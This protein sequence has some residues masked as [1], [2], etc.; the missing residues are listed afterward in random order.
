MPTEQYPDEKGMQTKA[1]FNPWGQKQKTITK[2]KYSSPISVTGQS[3]KCLK[4]AI[5]LTSLSFA[6]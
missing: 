3:F 5:M 2:N 4:A 6:S 1:R